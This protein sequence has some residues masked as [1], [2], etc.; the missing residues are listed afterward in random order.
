MGIIDIAVDTR[1]MGLSE[2]LP[3]VAGGK[4]GQGM[5][6]VLLRSQFSTGSHS[7]AALA[8]GEYGGRISVSFIGNLKNSGRGIGGPLNQVWGRV[9]GHK[10][11]I[12]PTYPTRVMYCRV[13]GSM[14]CVE[15]VGFGSNH[16]L[17]Y[18]D[19]WHGPEPTD[20]EI[21]ESR[22]FPIAAVGSIML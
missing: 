17:G 14:V 18:Q 8:E 22:L 19:F 13:L 10:L 5:A 21:F 1:F 12:N 2:C 4:C 15:F 20:K 16:L 7:G 9:G 6:T 11:Q 3:G